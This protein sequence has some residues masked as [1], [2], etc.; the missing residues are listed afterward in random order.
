[1]DVELS[2]AQRCSSIYHSLEVWQGLVVSHRVTLLHK[3][4]GS[5]EIAKRKWTAGTGRYSSE[6]N[7]IGIQI[8]PLWGE[9]AARREPRET[10][11][12]SPDPQHA[13]AA[14]SAP[15]SAA[16]GRQRAGPRGW[17]ASPAPSDGVSGPS[18][19]GLRRGLR[20]GNSDEFTVLSCDL[21]NG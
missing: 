4:S 8:P 9:A 3:E 7:L 21:Q 18:A 19:P 15:R 13:W 20:P 11:P 5:S 16:R 17:G 10:N 6:R 1:M 2:R 12:R 14:S